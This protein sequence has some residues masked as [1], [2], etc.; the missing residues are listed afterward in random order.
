M[1]FHEVHTPPDA[2]ATA[3]RIDQ[4]PFIYISNWR[5]RSCAFIHLLAQVPAYIHQMDTVPATCRAHCWLYI[6]NLASVNRTRPNSA[7]A[8]FGKVLNTYFPSVEWATHRFH[9]VFT[10]KMA[11]ASFA[12]I[13]FCPYIFHN[14]IVFDNFSPSPFTSFAHRTQASAPHARP[15]RVPCATVALKHKQRNGY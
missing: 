12:R 11:L 1:I 3:L 15:H 9:F 5:R 14:S 10:I 4:K 2:S 6:Y 8:Y 7:R 13:V